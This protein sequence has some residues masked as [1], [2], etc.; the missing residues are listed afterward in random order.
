[1][2][3]R[4][5]VV[6]AYGWDAS[7][8]PRL[9]GLG[10]IDVESVGSSAAQTDE[11]PTTVIIVNLSRSAMRAA[12]KAMGLDAQAE[13]PG[14]A[15]AGE[16]DGMG[17]ALAAQLLHRCGPAGTGQMQSGLPKRRLNRVVDYVREHLSHDLS[18]TELAR[19]ADMSP[20]HFKVLFK[21]S[22]GV[23]VHQYVIRSRVEY[24][25]EL[26]I[27]DRL[28]LKDIALQ[29]GFADQSHMAR[30]VRRLTGMAPSALKRK[31]S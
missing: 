28:P 16:L 22:L 21:Q 2:Q 6:A 18:L 7:F 29:A 31:V 13:Y 12:A 11:P 1:M 17:L 10:G 4:K 20:S 24:A 5:P 8:Q 14:S 3:L 23:P 30:C 27:A 19:V 9:H 25:I 26:L 15:L